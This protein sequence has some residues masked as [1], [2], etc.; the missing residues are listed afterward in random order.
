M[1]TAQGRDLAPIFGD[2]SQ[3]E[4]L[5]EIKQPLGGVKKVIK[6]GLHQRVNT[7]TLK[8][9]HLCLIDLNFVNL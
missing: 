7:C 4:K 9:P 2:L 3:G 8:S 1:N 6:A 5:S